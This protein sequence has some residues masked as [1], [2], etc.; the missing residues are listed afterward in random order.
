MKSKN[1]IYPIVLILFFL[2]PIVRYYIT[3]PWLNDCMTVYVKEMKDSNYKW[4][5]YNIKWVPHIEPANSKNNKALA[6]YKVWEA[7]WC[8]MTWDDMYANFTN[9]IYCSIVDLIQ[10][11]PINEEMKKPLAILKSWRVSL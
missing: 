10:N 4:N 2:L 11:A 5:I 7:R 6:Q 8:L 9:T 1:I 3:T